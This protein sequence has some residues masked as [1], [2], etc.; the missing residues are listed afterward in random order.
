VCM[1]VCVCVRVLN[2]HVLKRILEKKMCVT[3]GF[4]GVWAPVPNTPGSIC[5]IYVR[6]RHGID[7]V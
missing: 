5:F 1:C 6:V 2:N 3:C 4:R 7:L